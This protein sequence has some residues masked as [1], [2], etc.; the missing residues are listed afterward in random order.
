MGEAGAESAGLGAGEQVILLGGREG[1]PTGVVLGVGVEVEGVEAGGAGGG[2]GWEIGV[3]PAVALAFGELGVDTRGEVDDG[4]GA[5]RRH[6][7]ALGDDASGDGAELGELGDGER[8]WSVGGVV[9]LGSG[10]ED[11]AGGL[12]DTVREDEIDVGAIHGNLVGGNLVGR[13]RGGVGADA[14]AIEAV[15]ELGEQAGELGGLLH[16]DEVVGVE[17]GEAGVGPVRE[18]D[19]LLDVG[20]K[21]AVAIAGDE[22]D[23]Q[24]QDAD[25]GGP[26]LAAAVLKP[27]AP[28]GRIHAE[29]VVDGDGEE[30][31]WEVVRGVAL[32]VGLG[33]FVVLTPIALVVRRDGGATQGVEHMGAFAVGHGLG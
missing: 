25:A 16:G 26:V 14:V 2:V 23:G 3:A 4:C 33:G 17:G 30:L 19:G 12:A 7:A 24:R 6:G 29:D 27:G 22:E 20:A 1:Q 10:G 21:R 15:G 32:D 9:R 11:V 31:G 5:W 18:G 8:F 13:C 28:G